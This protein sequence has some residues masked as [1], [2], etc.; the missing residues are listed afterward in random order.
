MK[1]CALFS[2]SS[3][4]AI[5]IRSGKTGILLDAGLSGKSIVQA[6]LS[7]DENPADM[8]AILVSH[9]HSDHCKGVGILS[10]R[11]NV[12]VYASGGTWK[13]MAR[14][15][16]PVEDSCRCVFSAD[17]CFGIGDIEVSSFG[18]PHDAC[19][20]TG[21]SFLAEN[22]K[23]TVATDIGHLSKRLLKQLEGSDVL[24]IEANHDV[25]MLT[26]GSYPWPLKER[27]LGNY[28]HLS[29]E[30]AGDA[31]V[32][33]ANSGTRHFF[34]GHLSA[35]NNT[36]AKALAAVK[37]KIAQSGCRERDLSLVLADRHQRSEV[38]FI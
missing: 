14:S 15:I 30:L 27:I 21:F 6:L 16:G 24:L 17:T 36:P 13:G 18:I 32:H 25:D 9:E 29:N 8:S 2:G 35:E 7:I 10:R 4:N 19:E 31:V 33:A 20:P 34:L 3:G 1:F 5:F 23:V 12:P 38:L 11:F 28:G 37:D 22:S 26:T